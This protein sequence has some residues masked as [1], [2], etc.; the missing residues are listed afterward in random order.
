[1]RFAYANGVP[2]KNIF[3][4]DFTSCVCRFTLYNGSMTSDQ[5]SSKMIS[6]ARE[7][8]VEEKYLYDILYV[9]ECCGEYMTR[10]EVEHG[11]CPKCQ[12]HCD[13]EI[14][15]YFFPR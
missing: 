10:E 11:I 2:E 15:E 9:S 6:F 3:F 7:I 1:M 14:Q 13:V 12:E 4:V 8:Q 5:R